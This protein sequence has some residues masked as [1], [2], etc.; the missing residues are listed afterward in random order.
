MQ[1]LFP[2]IKKFTSFTRKMNRYGFTGFKRSSQK[3]GL[4]D[5]IF[6]YHHEL[7]RQ[8]ISPDIAKMIRIQNH[9]LAESAKSVVVYCTKT[10]C[11]MPASSTTTV[12]PVQESS[13]NACSNRDESEA[14]GRM[15]LQQYS[16]HWNTKGPLAAS[17]D[18]TFHVRPFG[19]R[20]SFLDMEPSNQFCSSSSTGRTLSR[21]MLT[22]PSPISSS[23]LSSDTTKQFLLGHSPV[24][25][26]IMERDFLLSTLIS[27]RTR[28]LEALLAFGKP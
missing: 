3:D 15:L 19:Y 26:A 8:G 5:E 18:S 24:S 22:S 14:L 28:A 7:F 13:G 12:A 23:M 17:S 25:Q 27:D 1:V 11:Q 4:T 20:S 2:G 16:S 9:N 6:I 21:L 10:P